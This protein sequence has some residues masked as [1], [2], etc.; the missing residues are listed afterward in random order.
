MFSLKPR[1]L[2]HWYRNHL[3]NYKPDIEQGNWQKDKIP[4][5]VDEQT[6]EILS[7]SPVYIA[8]PENMGPSM[9]LDDKQ[10]GK[11]VFS[12]MTNRETGKI[13]LLVETVK[14]NELQLATDFLG[15]SIE[16]VR[17]ISCDMSPSY[18]RFIQST[19]Q[20]S[21][22]VI[23]KFHVIR[24]VLDAVQNVRLEIKNQLL[25]SLPR[26]K[27]KT[28]TDHKILSELELLKRSKY[29]LTQ[30]RDKWTAYQMEIAGQVFEKY[31]RLKTA[32]QLSENF[33]RWYS[34][35]QAFKTRI[36]IEKDLYQW[37][38]DV[39]NSGLK[40]FRSVVKMIERHEQNI[41][42]Y[43]SSYQTNAKAENLN[44]KIQRF[45]SNNYGMKDKDFNLYRLSLYFS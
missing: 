23:D 4:K 28:A 2:Y 35:N 7:E 16:K 33:K 31:P 6:G 19:F 17:S 8:K 29:L 14:V 42:N 37:Y 39:E 3:S 34:P 11:D 10:I 24:Y 26:S 5:I 18:L 21:Q 12:I 1:T 27:R 25:E 15:D 13:A 36:I 44:G 32:Y 41:I 22:I 20:N 38:E 43:F 40:Q 30:S 9:V 45:I